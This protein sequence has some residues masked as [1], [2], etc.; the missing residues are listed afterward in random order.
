MK[1]LITLYW[2][3]LDRSC[4][5]GAN[6]LFISFRDV[7]NLQLHVIEVVKKGNKMEIGSNSFDL[8]DLDD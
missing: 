4:D 1:K 7:R 2:M 3:L 8:F 5:C 6:K